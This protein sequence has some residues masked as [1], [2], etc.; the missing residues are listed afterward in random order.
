L[1]SSPNRKAPRASDAGDASRITD[2]GSRI[3]KGIACA[4]RLASLICIIFISIIA[5]GA[6]GGSGGPVSVGPDGSLGPASDLED[7]IYSDA[8]AG[9][10]VVFFDPSLATQLE[11]SSPVDVILSDSE[12]SPEAKELVSTTVM[13]RAVDAPPE[14]VKAQRMKLEKLSG[15]SL[16]DWNLVYHVSAADPQYAVQILRNLQGLTSVDK[17]YPAVKPQLTTLMTTP[18]LTGHQGY[19][20][21][22]GTSGGLNAEAAW[23]AGVTGDNLYVIDSEPGMNF[24]HEEFDLVKA[25]LSEGGNY[26]YQPYCAPGFPEGLPDCDL[27]ISHGTAV[28]GILVAG[29][30]GHG[31]TG[32]APDAYF[33]NATTDDIT[34][35][36]LYGYTN[37]GD[38]DV[39]P[40]SIWLIE[41]AMPGKFSTGD[42]QYGQVPIELLPEVFSAI[43]QATA[44]GVTV[45]EGAGNGQMDL[46]NPELYTGD[47]DFAHDLSW[48]D[49][50][51]VMVGA[52]EGANEQKASFSN[53][54]S[55]IDAF[56]WGQGVATTGYPDGEVDWTG[57]TPPIPPNTDDDAFFIDNFGGTSAATA[58]VA[59]AAV[60][61]Q[62]Y[63]RQ[64]LGHRRYIMPLK[65]REILVDSGV[66]QADAGGNIGKQPRIDV[67]MG[68][69][70]T[71]LATVGT[72]YPQEGEMIALRALGVGIICKEFNPV[73]SDPS[74]PD[75]AVFPEGE[76]IAAHYDFDGDGRA[77]LVNFS[78]GGWK[79][80]LSSEGTAADGFGAWDVDVTYTAID[81]DCG[82]W[83][84]V[85][86]MNSDGRADFVA[87]DKCAGS[88]YVHLTDTALTR[89][90]V[91]H[92]WDWVIDYS[93]EW[94]DQMALDPDD[95][96]YSRPVIGDYYDTGYVKDG[97]NDIAILC[98]DGLVRIDYGNGTEAALGS[99][100]KMPQL[101]PSALLTDAPGWAYLSFMGDFQEDGSAFLGFKVP[102]GL[103]DEGRIYLLPFSGDQFYTEYD[104]AVDAPNIFGGNKTVPFAGRYNISNSTRVSVREP[105]DNWRI[106]NNTSYSELG[107]VAPTYIYDVNCHP[108]NGDFDGDGAVDRAVMCKDEWRIAYSGSDYDSMKDS[109][110]AR[111]VPLT[112]SGHK[113]PGRSYAGGISYSY[114]QQLMNLY[115]AQHPGEPVPIMVDM[116]SI[117][118][119]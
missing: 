25:P 108:L 117:S 91:W 110:G 87:Y 112:Y 59:G 42:D 107:D 32:F 27:F 88:F 34:D 116:I 114:A 9:H 57:S 70:D 71:F 111:H 81:G 19:L 104:W 37:G 3:T 62:S 109:D 97:F 98:S 118:S 14:K 82:V 38:D 20:E 50:G 60:L 83:P 68:L 65:M 55:R 12:G 39:E 31:V 35:P 100:E 49:A 6:C 66:A 73:A 16:T 95:A 1:W 77:D 86:D 103:A 22:E 96:D 69:V 53:H 105:N 106:T 46:D 58:I 36:G 51:A 23:T 92:G 47:W 43:E 26:L 80:D 45:I 72:S 40:G 115:Q 84:Y 30:N 44:Y 54:G 61:V 99:F 101:I 56:A 93:S 11:S 90:N 10:L 79:V 21:P 15:R 29:D 74:C 78:D 64:E 5:L 102:D 94:H 7:L 113:L 119:Q 8:Y 41:F 28:A 2:H 18:D 76:R 17:V 4:P 63:A 24:D 48:E 67:A 33:V 85:E 89:N 52:S 75:S 13:T